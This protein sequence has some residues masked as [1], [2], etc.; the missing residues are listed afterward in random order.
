LALL[1]LTG[2]SLPAG[3]VPPELLQRYALGRRGAPRDEVV[4]GPAL[5]EDSAVVDLGG[6]L[7][8]ISSDPITGATRNAGW[9]AVHVCCNDLGAMGAEP[10]GVL[11][12]LLLPSDDAVGHLERTM[13]DVHRACVDLGVAV[14]GGHSEVTA[15]LTAPILS[16]TAL[17]RAP[18]ERLVTSRG[19][20][21]GDQLILTKAAAIEGTAILATDF[22]DELTRELGAEAVAAG[23]GFYDE[24]SVVREGVA[25]AAAGA[26]AMHDVTEGGVLGALYELAA[27]SGVGFAVR[28]ADVPVRP[29]TAAICH[30]LGLDPLRLL[31]SG[32]LLIAA[33]DGPAL[34]GALA[35][36]GI[37]ATILGRALPRRRGRRLL[38]PAGSVPLGP[39]DRDELYR[40]FAPGPDR[41]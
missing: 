1:A 2:E 5:G 35:T 4:V 36:H 11:V 15:G 27:A 30:T 16:L 26:S 37:P 6:Q 10:V 3:K 22:A 18:R 40:A 9:L 33:P 41:T 12:T 20:S 25:A 39:T 34:V 21:P 14:L 31:G 32:A 23:Q 8:V 29:E 13:A 24:I 17:G 7:A 19:A 38:T 28:A